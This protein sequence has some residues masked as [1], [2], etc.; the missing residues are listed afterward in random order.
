MKGRILGSLLALNL[1]MG[2]LWSTEDQDPIQQLVNVVGQAV[3]NGSLSPEQI[4][5]LGSIYQKIKASSCVS[6]IIDAAKPVEGESFPWTVFRIVGSGTVG[7][8][9]FMFTSFVLTQG[10]KLIRV[11][12]PISLVQ[13]G[14]A[15]VEVANIPIAFVFGGRLMVKTDQWLQNAENRQKVKNLGR[16]ILDTVTGKNNQKPQEQNQT[17]NSNQNPHESNPSDNLNNTDQ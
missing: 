1:S 7:Y 4:Q 16:R 12:C 17:D 11:F 9:L 13:Q 14:S 15:I 2:A 3:Q 6:S 10:S 5:S 8:S